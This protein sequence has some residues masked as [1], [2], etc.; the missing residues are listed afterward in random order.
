M[1]CGAAVGQL[2][3]W[4]LTYGSGVSLMGLYGSLMGLYGVSMGPYVSLW[5][6]Y[7]S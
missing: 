1:S 2:W 3:V 4:G 7:G 6:L 5:G